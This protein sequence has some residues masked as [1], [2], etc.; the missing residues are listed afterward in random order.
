MVKDDTEMG[1]MGIGTRWQ[2]D[3]IYT[4]IE[5]LIEP[6]NIPTEHKPFP[7]Q[8]SKPPGYLI[9]FHSLGQTTAALKATI[10]RLEVDPGPHRLI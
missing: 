9:T 10:P 2:H 8:S 3:D 4:Y 5:Q 6:A 1:G 7:H